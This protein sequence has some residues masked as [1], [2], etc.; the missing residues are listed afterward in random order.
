MRSDRLTTVSVT[1]DAFVDSR[2]ERMLSFVHPAMA[3]SGYSL[4]CILVAAHYCHMQA[5]FSLHFYSRYVAV[6]ISG[7]CAY[8]ASVVF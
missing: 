2:T 5:H 4:V 8:P 7:S 6:P 3:L 1:K